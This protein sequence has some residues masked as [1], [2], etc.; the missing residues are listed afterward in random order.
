MLDTERPTE[1][2][3][4]IEPG[5]FRCTSVDRFRS[6]GDSQTRA[7]QSKVVDFTLSSSRDPL[8]R[9]WESLLSSIFVQDLVKCTTLYQNVRANIRRE[10]HRVV[11]KKL[12]YP[13]QIIIFSGI[14]MCFAEI[15]LIYLY[16]YYQFL[17]VLLIQLIIELF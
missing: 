16:S 12:N 6:E 2:A 9:N 8:Q 13:L 1:P 17:S 7:F 10:F 5:P 4:Q 14:H 11:L 15:F 3:V